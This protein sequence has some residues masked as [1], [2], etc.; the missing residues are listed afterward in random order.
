VVGIILGAEGKK[1]LTFQTRLTRY[2]KEIEFR[3]TGKEEP[4]GVAP[5][6]TF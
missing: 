5:N 3:V 6:L 2:Y 4:F 1:Y